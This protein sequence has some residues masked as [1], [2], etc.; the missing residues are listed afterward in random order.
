MKT[1]DDIM[2]QQRRR[3]LQAGGAAIFG[4]ASTAA[5]VRRELGIKS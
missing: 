5:E 3:I 1:H 2:K 4:R